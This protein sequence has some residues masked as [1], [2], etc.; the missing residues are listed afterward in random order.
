MFHRQSPSLSCRL[1]PWDDRP[2]PGTD[3]EEF[4]RLLRIA[5]CRR[6]ADAPG[7]DACHTREPFDQA[8]GLSAAVAAHQRVQLIDDD[9]SQVAEQRIDGG[10][11]VQQH[12]FE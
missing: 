1:D 7:V 5:D 2:F 3:T 12:G 6:Q 8:Q 11:T 4:R 9:E 10:M